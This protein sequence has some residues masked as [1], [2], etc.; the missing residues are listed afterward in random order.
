MNSDSKMV[1]DSILMNRTEFLKVVGEA[2]QQNYEVGSDGSRQLEFTDLE[3]NIL[4]AEAY[5]GGEQF[6][7]MMD[8][9]EIKNW[10]E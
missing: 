8:N 10:T 5:G 6:L 9:S 1:P 3:K 2:D 4:N 7:S